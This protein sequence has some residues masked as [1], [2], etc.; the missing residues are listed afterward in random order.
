MER[1]I[2][3]YET[4]EAKNLTPVQKKRLDRTLDKLG[5]PKGGT[6]QINFGRKEPITKDSK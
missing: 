2:L 4:S 5:I 6:V 1:T 3:D